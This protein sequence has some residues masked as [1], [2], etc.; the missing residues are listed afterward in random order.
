MLQQTKVDTVIPY[1]NR[2]IERFPDIASLASAEED[3]VLKLWE[4]L[5]YYSRARNLLKAARM[6]VESYNGIF[7]KKGRRSSQTTRH[8][9]L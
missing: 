4:G 6:I 3:E 9:A 2:F 1:F 5:G 8:R 7:P